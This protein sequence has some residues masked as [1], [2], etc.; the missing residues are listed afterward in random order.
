MDKEPLKAVSNVIE[1]KPGH[2]YLLVLK[3]DHIDQFAGE[4]ANVLLRGMG[5]E[6]IYAQIGSNDDLQ[7]IE[8]PPEEVRV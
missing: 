7:V 8:I 2:K 4:R 1:L 6:S 5:V 3:G